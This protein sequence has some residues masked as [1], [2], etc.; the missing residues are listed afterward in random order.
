MKKR[1]FTILG[2]LAAIPLVVALCVET[3]FYLWD[4][5]DPPPPPCCAP[6]QTVT[7]APGPQTP[8][9]TLPP[10]DAT[11]FWEALPLP[12]DAEIEPVAEGVDLA[13]STA[14][15]EGQI[16]T[17]YEDWLQTRGWQPQ[18]ADEPP[19]RRIWRYGETELLIEIYILNERGRLVVWV[20]I[21]PPAGTK[22]SLPDALSPPVEEY[23]CG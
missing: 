17:F 16:F 2:I 19:T 21:P 7:R 22:D 15:V 4:F 10:F 9:P 23:Q 11:S 1:I 20:Q 14:W 5:F 3:V 6:N 12:D 8:T 18:P 13:F